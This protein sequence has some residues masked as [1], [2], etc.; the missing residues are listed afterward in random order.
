MQPSNEPSKPS[1]PPSQP[2]PEPAQASR[3][4]PNPTELLQ[5]LKGQMDSGAVTPQDS[6]RQQPTTP[7]EQVLANLD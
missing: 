5:W 7:D 4:K 3:S 1:A 2:S 6:Q